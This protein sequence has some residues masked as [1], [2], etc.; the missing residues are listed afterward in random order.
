MPNKNS[1]LCLAHQALYRIIA[2]RTNL[3]TLLSKSDP[4]LEKPIQMELVYGVLRHYYFLKAEL[5]PFLEKKIKEKDTDIEVLILMGIYQI[6]FMKVPTYAAVNET[7]SIC[8]E[9]Q[10]DWAKGLVN[11][12]LR[13]ISKQKPP[14]SYPQA[15]LPMWIADKLEEEFPE[16]HE[17]IKSAFL[18]KPRMTLRINM[19]KIDPLDYRKKLVKSNIPVSSTHLEEAITLDDAQPSLSLPG[20]SAGEVSIQDFGAIVLSRLFVEQIQKAPITNKRILDACSAPGGKLFHIFELLEKLSIEASISALEIQ[21]KRI[22][23]M[24][25]T[26]LRLG[27]TVDINQGDATKSDW[28]DQHQYTHILVDAP[29]SSSGTIARNPDVKVIIDRNRIKEYQEKQFHILVNLWDKLAPGGTIFYCTCSLFIE[30]NDLLIQR[31][32]AI[33]GDSILSKINM[34]SEISNTIQTNCGWY[35]LPLD[36]ISV[37]FYCS[38]ISKAPNPK[39]FH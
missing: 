25:D 39:E 20:W 8:E 27:H 4:G 6:Y 37:G 26:A 11:A 38:S 28:W 19:S 13:K 21:S 31:F 30:E 23:A 36:K 7:V 22:K 29:C 9:I 2:K 10:K 3:N 1:T 15:D 5:T 18:T 32:L 35:L 17:K 24:H 16:F 14:N 12:L 34:P 33:Q